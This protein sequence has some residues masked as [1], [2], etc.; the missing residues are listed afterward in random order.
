MIIVSIIIPTYHASKNILEAA[1]KSI[2]DQSSPKG[3][4]E[5]I[6]AD[7]NGGPEIKSLAKKYGLKIVEISGNPPQTCNQVNKGAKTAKGEYIFILDHD[8][9]LS[10]NL[11]ENF[12]KQALDKKDID[13]WYVPYKIVA[14]GY[15][16]NKIRNFEETFYKNSVIAAARI[17]KKKIFFQTEKQYDPLLNLGP[18]D[19]D[20]TNQLKIM[21]AKFD[22]INDYVYHHEE[23]LNF[24]D[25]TKK[26]TLYSKGGELYKQKWKTKNLRIYNEIVKKQYDPFYRLFG[27]FVEKGKWRKLLAELSM[28]FLFLFIKVSMALVYVYSLKRK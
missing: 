14:R 26:K 5:V 19:W 18:G 23:H 24:W 20:L 8:I 22:Y 1:L 3:L 16:L 10:P 12:I 7:N 21:D 2:A 17:I 15:L 25:F 4:Y 27:I 13:A 9:T 11:L 6:L 28:Y